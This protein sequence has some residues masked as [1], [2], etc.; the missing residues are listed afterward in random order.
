MRKHTRKFLSLFLS[1]SMA[2]SFCIPAMAAEGDTTA[3]TDDG[4]VVLYTNDVHCTSDDGMSYAA[5]AAYKAEMEASYG[6]D[7]VTLVD[8]GDAIQGG[9]LGSLSKGSWIVDIMNNVGY[10]IAIPGNHEFDFGMD[11]FLDI[12]KNQAEYTYVSC[13][14]VDADGKAVLEPYTMVTY[15]DVDVAYVG[16][17]TPET[18]TKSAPAYFPNDKG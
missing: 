15:G 6:A 9:I 11:T 17:S 14:F 16:I 5:I 10:D 7:N 8:N 2:S 3:A 1:L 12:A 4:I 13:N 18:L